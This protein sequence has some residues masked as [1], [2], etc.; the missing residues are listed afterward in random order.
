M[1]SSKVTS[2]SNKVYLGING[3][4]LASFLLLVAVLEWGRTE[5][6]PTDRIQRSL[7]SGTFHLPFL[8]ALHHPPAFAL[9]LASPYPPSTH[10]SPQTCN[11]LKC[12]MHH[13][14]VTQRSEPMW[15]FL[16]AG[17]NIQCW[18]SDLNLLP[19]FQH[20]EVQLFSFPS[21]AIWNGS[22]C[23]ERTSCCPLLTRHVGSGFANTPFS[24]LHLFSDLVGPVG[25]SVWS[26]W[27]KLLF[28]LSLFPI[29]PT[30]AFSLSS[31]RF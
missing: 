22:S 4:F 10:G 21:L 5:S 25:V 23:V 28:P 3:F 17:W 31:N 16:E 6:A 2:Q 14:Q 27:W 8:P 11:S 18:E 1:K 19:T 30:L 26:P 13:K 24:L 12:P 20:L 7:F 29:A 9:T 15:Q